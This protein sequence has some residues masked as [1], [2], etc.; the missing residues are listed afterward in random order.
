MQKPI[1]LTLSKLKKKNDLRVF[2]KTAVFRVKTLQIS[3]IF[4]ENAEGVLKIRQFELIIAK[5]YYF[6]NVKR[7]FG[8]GLCIK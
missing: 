1:I 7:L 3:T 6:D 4:V 2:I 5:L 8:G